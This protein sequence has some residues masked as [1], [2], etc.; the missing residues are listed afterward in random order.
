MSDGTVD[1]DDFLRTEPVIEGRKADDGSPPSVVD[2]LRI[3]RCQD[4]RK[5]QALEKG[6]TMR[7]DRKRRK[8]TNII[9]PSEA[10]P[11]ESRTPRV[12][13]DIF[14]LGRRDKRKEKKG[15]GIREEEER[16]AGLSASGVGGQSE[17]N[18]R[19]AEGAEKENRK[20]E[21]KKAVE[22]G[23]RGVSR[24]GRKRRTEERRS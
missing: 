14:V 6:M 18:G 16:S 4:A 15:G 2:T 20:R 21:G 8:R 10:N 11:V 5:E 7:R 19:L 12:K 1:A 22:Q 3:N 24:M 17:P 23:E 13:P 9:A